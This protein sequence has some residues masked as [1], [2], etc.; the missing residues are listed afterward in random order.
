MSGFGSAATTALLVVVAVAIGALLG[1]HRGPRRAHARSRR[2]LEVVWAPALAVGIGLR[3]LVELLTVPGGVVLLLASYA[4]L[5]AVC[6]KN[7]T[8]TG[9]PIVL[10]GLGL[11]VLPAVLDGGTPVSRDALSR[12]GHDNPPAALPG[13]RH[14]EVERDQLRVLGDTLPLPLGGRPTSFGELILLVGVGD[15][16]FNIAARR[17]GR[18]RSASS[19]AEGGAD[20]LADLVVAT[21]PLE[22]EPTVVVIG[23]PG[24]LVDAAQVL[25]AAR[26]VDD[27][28]VADGN[29]GLDEMQVVPE[30]SARSGAREIRPS[31]GPGSVTRSS[32]GGLRLFDVEADDADAIAVGRRVDE[33]ELGRRH[34]QR[35]REP[36]LSRSRGGPIPS[37]PAGPVSLVWCRWARPS[38]TGASGPRSSCSSWACSPASPAWSAGPQWR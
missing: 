35:G 6:V 22:D 9:T 36:S 25:D 28:Q 1:G 21:D 27:M 4:L 20:S 24:Q 19:I 3:L 13:E 18:R 14:L 2:T 12:M 15:V 30:A 16:A 11:M 33:R 34:P 17:N 38:A 26:V 32:G 10:L 29:P 5:L 23:A 37:W 8:W 7:L 31:H